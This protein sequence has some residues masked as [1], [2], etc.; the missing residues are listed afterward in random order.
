[1][2]WLILATAFMPMS[3]KEDS[4]SDLAYWGTALVLGVGYLASGINKLSSPSWLNGDAIL[5]IAENPVAH[6]YISK[7]APYFNTFPILITKTLTW[8][9]LSIELLFLPLFFFS[10]T[11]K[12]IWILATLWHIGAL[13][14]VYLPFV[15]VGMIIFHFYLFDLNWFNKKGKD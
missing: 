11:R 7:L 10:K 12:W 2:G 15:S 5:Y 4:L 3:D 14:T 1:M 9:I 13:I 6:V 8:L